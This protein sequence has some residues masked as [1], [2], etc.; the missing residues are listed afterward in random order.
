MDAHAQI[1]PES[2]VNHAFVELHLLISVDDI[3]MTAVSWCFFRI[4]QSINSL[5]LPSSP[6]P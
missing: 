4:F 1:L 5:F 2:T 3:Q 6:Y